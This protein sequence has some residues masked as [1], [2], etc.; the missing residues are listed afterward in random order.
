MRRGSGAGKRWWSGA[1]AALVAG[2]AWVG[3]AAWAEGL[4]PE[5][6]SRAAAPVWRAFWAVTA[7]HRPSKGEEAV[8]RF[9]ETRAAARGCPAERDQAGNLLVRVPATP[10]LAGR[11]STA[12]QGHLDMVCVTRPGATHR[13]G[14]DS[15]RPVVRDGWLT[16]DDTSLGADNGLGVAAMVALLEGPD[17]AVR[18]GPL[19]LLFTVDEEGDFSGVCGL[20]PGWLQ[21]SRLINLDSEEDGEFNIGCAGGQADTL[22]FDG[23]RQE[24]PP[25]HVW[26]RFSVTGGLGG[27]SGVDIH[28]GRANAIVWLARFLIRVSATVPI[29]L[30]SFTGGTVDTAIPTA[31]SAIVAV[32]AREWPAVRRAATAFQSRLHRWFATTDPG[33]R[34]RVERLPNRSAVGALR[35]PDQDRGASS[36]ADASA[37]S[38]G[39]L[40]VTAFSPERSAQVLAALTELPCGIQAMSRRFPGQ[41]QTSANPGVIR[42]ATGPL[43]LVSHLQG[44]RLEAIRWLSWRWQTVADR[45]GGALERGEPYPS[46]EPAAS[47]PLTDAAVAVHERLCGRRPL[48]KVVHAGLECG[49]MAPL[50]PD[51]DMLSFGPAIVG[52]HAPGERVEIASV[53]R[54]W[55]L[56]TT[57]LAALAEE[58]AFAAGPTDTRSEGLPLRCHGWRRETPVSGIARE[59]ADACRR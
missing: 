53:D 1:L 18:H 47:S 45:F 10:G 20:R 58:P 3:G 43:R 5:L 36:G 27:H 37:D 17:L 6:E 25:G 13:W 29:R 23:A 16:A 26:A 39:S 41:V 28:R 49:A 19:E 8:R 59:P 44:S 21:S 57:L 30:G 48:L 51:L 12:L 4:P 35:G 46:W 2:A 56:L 38:V 54:F 15:I 34:F 22:T 24:P 42:L 32:P 14:I 50:Y 7:I 40:P 33:L 31:A 55:A 11:P 52:P 9:I